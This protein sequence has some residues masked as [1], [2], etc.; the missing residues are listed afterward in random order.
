MATVIAA[1][2]KA[3]MIIPDATYGGSGCVAGTAAVTLSA[4]QLV[5]NALF[6]NYQAEI[7][8]NSNR[9]LDRK[10]CAIAVP[11]RVRPGY[12]YAV[13]RVILKTD[14][15]LARGS[16]AIY[17]LEIF[18]PSSRPVKIEIPFN[19]A[20][21]NEQTLAYVMRNSDWSTCGK[22]DL[23]RVNTSVILKSPDRRAALAA[24]RDRMTLQLQWRRCR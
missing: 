11:I 15:V 14:L 17:S 18:R 20:I 10:A 16:S 12:Q 3:E 13:K 7:P 1:R 6:D 5:I 21:N 9:S 19:G 23:L 22:S 24:V 2:A 4:D 8:R